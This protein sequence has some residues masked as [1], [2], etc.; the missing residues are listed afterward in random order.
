MS[1][2]RLGGQRANGSLRQR[3]KNSKERH[4]GQRASG[5]RL[6]YPAEVT[7]I[8]DTFVT[9]LPLGHKGIYQQRRFT[10]PIP[11]MPDIARLPPSW[12]RRPYGIHRFPCPHYKHVFWN[13]S[14][15]TQHCNAFHGRTRGQSS[16]PFN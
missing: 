15:L 6:T 5:N 11:C 3:S 4:Y 12:G 9:I 10:P 8:S 14:G 16:L 2:F 13:I 7:P 1:D